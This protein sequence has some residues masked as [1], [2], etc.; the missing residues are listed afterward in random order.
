MPMLPCFL[1]YNQQP[2]WDSIPMPTIKW[3]PPHYSAGRLPVAVCIQYLFRKF[4]FFIQLNK[5]N[6][7]VQIINYTPTQDPWFENK[8]RSVSALAPY[9]LEPLDY[10]W[11]IH[12]DPIKSI[13]NFASTQNQSSWPKR[14]LLLSFRSLLKYGEKWICI[15]T[16]IRELRLPSSPAVLTWHKC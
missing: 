5:W 11:P 2:H 8:L 16:C 9:K 14:P 4:W 6:K 15:K 1:S 3:K 13:F 7:K 10:K 12:Q